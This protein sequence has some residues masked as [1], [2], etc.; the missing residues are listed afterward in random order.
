M[1]LL[2]LLLRLLLLHLRTSH[3]PQL[4][5]MARESRSAAIRYSSSTTCRSDSGGREPRDAHPI[6][7]RYRERVHVHVHVRGIRSKARMS[8]ERGGRKAGCAW[9][10]GGSMGGG[11]VL[12]GL[13]LLLLLEVCLLEVGEGA[14]QA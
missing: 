7:A 5:S 10:L 11:V 12:L 3:K 6:S 9:G 1:C 14:C 8:G 4:S 2:S 13:L